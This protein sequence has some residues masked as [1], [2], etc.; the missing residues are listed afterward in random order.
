[1]DFELAVKIGN[2]DLAVS[3]LMDEDIGKYMQI[4]IQQ[5]RES[6]RQGNCGFGSVIFKNNEIVSTAHDT[7]KTDS[8]PTA[9]AEI[10][11]I[12]GAAKKLGRNLEGCAIVSTHE[13]CPMCAAAIVWAGIQKVAF[14]FTIQDAI[15]QGRT[16]IDMPCEEIFSRAA[17][18]IDIVKRVML[19]ECAVLYDQNVRNEIEKL[20]NISDQGLKDLETD[21]CR[22]RV[23]WFAANK[24]QTNAEGR[25]D[26]QTA[27]DLFVEKLGVSPDDAPVVRR[28]ED[29]LTIHSRNFCPT[30]EACTILGL[31]T[32][33]VCKRYT[34]KPM[35]VLLQQIRPNLRFERNYERLRPHA[36]Y[37]EEMI[38]LEDQ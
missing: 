9:H 14:G 22:K 12:R 7:E 4:A 1:M 13:P 19:E 30:L 32:R 21:L 8:D 31:D 38:V 25:D 20:R 2:G 37:C 15:A 34:E 28:D 6:L 23:E 5:A 10:L 29:R 11:A 3:K 18:S 24:R 33:H 17:E 36:E 26:L 35:N 27:Y 16:R